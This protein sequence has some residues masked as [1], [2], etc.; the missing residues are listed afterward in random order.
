M[1]VCVLSLNAA[2]K[3]LLLLWNDWTDYKYI[4]KMSR[5]QYNISA[6]MRFGP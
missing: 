4:I 2:I 3:L 1:Y 5:V 6:G